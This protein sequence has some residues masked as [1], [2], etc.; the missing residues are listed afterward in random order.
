MTGDKM[1]VQW[2]QTFLLTIGAPPLP[3]PERNEGIMMWIRFLPNDITNYEC[4][5]AVRF[6][7]SQFKES[8]SCEFFLFNL[9]PLSCLARPIP[10]WPTSLILLL[11]NARPPTGS[12]RSTQTM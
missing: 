1:A 8:I 12:K 4:H 2:T 9:L 3:L 6:L 11:R 5:M 10:G 7:P